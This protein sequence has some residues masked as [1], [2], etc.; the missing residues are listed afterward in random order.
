MSIHTFRIIALQPIATRSHTGDGCQNLIF[1]LGQFP[2][3][4]VMTVVIR[5]FALQI[6]KIAQFQFFN[7]VYLIPRDGLK[8][9]PVYTLAVLVSF[10]D[11]GGWWDR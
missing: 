9:K 10:H 11:F 2:R 1:G 6:V 4:I 7:A 3:M 8:V 5:A